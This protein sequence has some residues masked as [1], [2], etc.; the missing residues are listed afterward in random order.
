MNV[1]MNMDRREFLLTAFAIAA[2]NRFALGL[3]VLAGA[4]LPAVAAVMP[5]EWNVNYPVDTPYEVELS[6]LK[7]EKLAGIDVKC[8]YAVMADGRELPTTCFAGKAP[9]TIDLRFTVPSGT[10]SL[11][12]EPR[13]DVRL[14]DSSR[15]DNVFA[16]ALDAVNLCRW[17][18]D[19]GL[20][21]SPAGDGILFRDTCFGK[22]RDASYTVD[23][24]SE[25]AGRTCKVE[26]DVTSKSKMVWGGD[27]RIEQLDAAG[28]VLPDSVSDPRWTSQMR[29]PEKFTSYREDGIFH[30]KAR[31]LRLVIGLRSKDVDVDSYGMPLKDKSWLLAKLL[32]TRIAVRPAVQLPFPKYDDRHFTAGVSG[33]AG[34]TA[35]VL[36]GALSG[37]FWYQTRSQG[38]WAEARQIRDERECY[39]PN[40]AGTIEA[41]FKADWASCKGDA[42]TLFQANHGY[43]PA[44]RRDG[45][46]DIV[47][48]TWNRTTSR[49]RLTMKDRTYGSFAFDAEETH[50]PANAWFHLAVAWEP[51]NVA[52]VFVDGKQ[53][54]EGGLADFKPFDISDRTVKVPNDRGAMELFVGCDWAGTRGNV[55]MGTSTEYPLVE[56]A[57]DQLRISTGCRYRDEFIPSRKLDLD[58]DTRAKFDFDRSFD[59]RSSGGQGRILGSYRTMADRIDHQLVLGGRKVQYYPA[60]L[61]P[62][63]DPDEVLNINNYRLLPKP[64]EYTAAR[65][66]VKRSFRLRTGEKVDYTVPSGAY[67]DF[68]EV[69]N[70]GKTTLEF[71][72]A[73]NRGELDVR[74]FGDCAD[75]LNLEG[76]SDRD[77]VNRLFQMVISASDYFMNHNATF[78]YGSDD[79][80]SVCY[81]AMVVLNSYCGFECG[82]LNNMTANMFVTVAGCP[83]VQTGGYGHSFEE[84]FYDGKNHIYDL[85]AQKFFPSMDNESAAYLREVGDQPGI[86]NRVA[87]SPD[88]FMRKSTRGHAVQNPDYREKLGV[89]LRPG[90]A[91]R[92]WRGNNGEQ[93]N[94]Q[95]KAAKRGPFVWD[96]PGYTRTFAPRYEEQTHA[97]A[98]KS[99]IRRIDRFFPDVSSGFISFEGRPEGNP[100]FVNV[101]GSSF[102]YDVKVGYPITWASYAAVRK[103]GVPAELEISTDF[104]TFRRLPGPDADGV[105][106][107]DYQVRARHGYWIRVKAPIGDIVRFEAITEVMVNRR[108]FPGHAMPGRHELMLKAESDGIAKVTVQWRENVKEIKVSG[109]AFSGTIPGYERQTFVL[110]PSR[111]LTLAVDGAGPTARAVPT[112]GL[113]ASLAEGVLKIASKETKPFI[114][115]VTIVDGD[116]SRELTVVVCEGA[117]LALAAEGEV[118]GGARI[119]AA[120]ADRVQSAVML[121]TDKKDRVV[122]RFDKIPAGKYLIFSLS[123][124]EGGLTKGEGG[125]KC[126]MVRLPGGGKDDF[127]LTGAASNGNCDFLKAPYGTRGGRGNWKWD[128]PFV[129][130]TPGSAWSGWEVEPEP[131]AETSTLEY[132]MNRTKE[133]GVEL[134]ACCIIPDSVD[135]DFRGMLKKLLCGLNCQPNRTVSK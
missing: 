71:P 4:C 68:V 9:G 48:L 97:N 126:Y 64:A 88:H 26:F 130:E 118:K 108:T 50:L 121:K 98:A 101:D 90:E 122:F 63:N 32:V 42:I 116:A 78:D 119:L 29:P 33:E 81:D 6:P 40:G 77:R 75:C 45:K 7:L 102:C 92:V 62:E 35:L 17:H 51:G 70:I 135:Q 85:A 66:E 18:L 23:L 132:V 38:G 43:S 65:R 73:I 44:E 69:A 21:A 20:Q 89:T 109:G 96:Q 30:P 31:K 129:L 36:G 39:F 76:A 107:L 133:A 5:L 105:T 12:C 82:P 1:P 123:R 11:T 84:V 83:A 56:G 27:I 134:A 10:K 131:F 79:P 61:L 54:L 99:P 59:G 24:P 103:D 94:L 124:F 106:R 22:E 47:A 25:L 111:G 53:V 16:G 15:I 3:S 8:G 74:S 46:G 117:R 52:K 127:V 112:K 110:E 49:M 113:E 34:D 104:K 72:L 120:D 60:E 95:C 93:N 13:G 128:Y 87:Y 80:R 14:A 57:V 37:G 41:W 58:G 55:L 114:G 115:A 2:A 86:H 125:K 19:E 28:R 91:F 67:P 100:A